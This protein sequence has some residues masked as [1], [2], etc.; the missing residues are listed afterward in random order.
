MSN[1]QNMKTQTSGSLVY[2]SVRTILTYLLRRVFIFLA[3]VLLGKAASAQNE[4]FTSGSFIINMGATNPNTV[5]NGL[6]P[7]GLIYDLL[8]NYQVPIKWVVNTSK[9]KDGIDL[10]YNGTPFKGGTFV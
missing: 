6:K 8:R 5:A 3:V 9:V 10:S 1:I 2:V 4:V 7:Y